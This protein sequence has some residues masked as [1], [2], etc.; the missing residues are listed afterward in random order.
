MNLCDEITEEKAKA[1]ATNFNAKKVIYKTKIFYILLTF[2]LI[3]I[4]RL[5]AVSIYCY[6]IKYRAKQKHLPCYHTSK[7]KE[8]DI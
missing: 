6:L 5:I 4:A 2:L 1:T 8:I 3:T 7:L